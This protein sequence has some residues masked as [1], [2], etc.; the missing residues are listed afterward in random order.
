MTMACCRFIFRY[1]RL[2]TS[3]VLE[4]V[5]LVRQTQSEMIYVKTGRQWTTEQPRPTDRSQWKKHPRYDSR[6]INRSPDR[7]DRSDRSDWRQSRSSSV[8]THQAHDSPRRTH[9]AHD[10][11][12][13]TH[14]AHDSPH[15]KYYSD[16]QTQGELQTK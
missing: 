13:S 9:Q 3:I 5:P 16:R 11:P 6:L 15:Q 12:R 10:S 2:L 4:V 7:S 8:R 14:Q 1:F